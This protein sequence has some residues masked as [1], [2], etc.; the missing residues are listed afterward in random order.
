MTSASVRRENRGGHKWEKPRNDRLEP[1]STWKSGQPREPKRQESL[2]G[3]WPCWH[4]DF[5]LLA[6]K[7][8]ERIS[9]S[10]FKVSGLWYFFPAAL[11]H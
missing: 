9:F 4:R 6:S 5:R 2:R 3:R 1:R 10:Y 8:N 11:G 7:N